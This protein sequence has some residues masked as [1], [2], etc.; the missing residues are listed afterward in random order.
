MSVSNY[1]VVAQGFCP[2]GET[3][4][5]KVCYE[6]H[7]NVAKLSSVVLSKTMEIMVKSK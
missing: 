5:K 6:T 4:Y 3:G 7:Q 2:D 1:K